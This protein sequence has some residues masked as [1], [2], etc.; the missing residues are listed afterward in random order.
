V[1]GDGAAIKDRASYPVGIRGG[2]TGVENAENRDKRRGG[3][4]FAD[5]RRATGGGQANRPQ[6]SGK[7]E[8]LQR[9]RRAGKKVKT[10]RSIRVREVSRVMQMGHPRGVTQ[11]GKGKNNKKGEKR[12]HLERTL[13]EN[14]RG[15]AGGVVKG[16]RKK[17]ANLDNQQEPRH[18][19][20]KRKGLKKPLSYGG[21]RERC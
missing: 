18:G 12:P 3:K 13:V 10:G 17:A 19:K 11:G 6:S 9:D 20:A 21:P 15:H 2:G 8:H 4:K 1:Q 16:I 14:G 5:G 7:R